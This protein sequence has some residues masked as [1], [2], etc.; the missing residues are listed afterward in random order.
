MHDS[1]AKSQARA[2]SPERC[3]RLVHVPGNGDAGDGEP[4]DR[5]DG[6]LPIGGK[7]VS[8]SIDLK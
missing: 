6:A 3:L 2:R 5:W 8:A 1:R 4:L 7:P